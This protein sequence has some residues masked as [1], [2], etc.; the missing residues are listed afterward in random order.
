MRGCK[1]SSPFESSVIN[2]IRLY[3]RWCA[4]LNGYPYLVL[5]PSLSLPLHPS[6][7]LPLF[8]SSPLP[9]SPSSPLPPSS[10]SP[11]SP[12]P[13]PSLSPPSPLPLPSLS[14]PLPPL[15]IKLFKIMSLFKQSFTFDFIIILRQIAT[16]YCKI[17]FT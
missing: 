6:P 8:P 12:L 4:E 14:P 1:S 7:P 13:L 10:L 3:K 2:L 15:Y 5:L 9:L 17:S 16:R 11:P